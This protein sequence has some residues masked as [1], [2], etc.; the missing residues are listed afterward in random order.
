MSWFPPSVIEEDWRPVCSCFTE[1][2]ASLVLTNL[3]KPIRSVGL[4]IISLRMAKRSCYFLL[5][6]LCPRTPLPHI[7]FLDTILF[8]FF[9]FSTTKCLMEVSELEVELKSLFVQYLSRAH[10][11]PRCVAATANPTDS[12]K[13]TRQILHDFEKSWAPR[14]KFWSSNTWIKLFQCFA[15]HFS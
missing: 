8:F 14:E 9:G 7:K 13:C 3:T 1:Q 10:G 15:L 4:W 12:L 11:N 6:N 5:Y 2:M